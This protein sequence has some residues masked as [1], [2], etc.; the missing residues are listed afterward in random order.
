[1]AKPHI[2][3]NELSREERLALIE[4]LWDSLAGQPE[5]LPLTRAQRHELDRRIDE[6]DGD[7][8]LGIPWEGVLRQIRD[9]R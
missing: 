7:D 2:D 8:T 4:E 3:V 9:Q 1:M 6:M 5:E